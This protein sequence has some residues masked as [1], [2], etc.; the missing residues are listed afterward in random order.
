MWLSH[1]FSKDSW[2]AGVHVV[3]RV[4]RFRVQTRNSGRGAVLNKVQRSSCWRG[5]EWK[6]TH[7]CRRAAYN[8]KINITVTER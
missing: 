5:E 7:M 6:R 2:R 4:Q 1:Y 3:H 8:W